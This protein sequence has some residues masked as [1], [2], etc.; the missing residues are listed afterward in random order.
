LTE[1]DPGHMSSPEHPLPARHAP[2]R[3]LDPSD[4]ADR[5]VF[6][7]ERWRASEIVTQAAIERRTRQRLGAFLGL[8]LATGVAAGAFCGGGCAAAGPKGEATSPPG[9]EEARAEIWR[10]Y[11]RTDTPPTITIVQGDDL[12]C[13]QR[14]GDPGFPAFEFTDAEKRLVG[15]FGGHTMSYTSVKVAWWPDLRPSRSSTAHEFMH[16]LLVRTGI[17]LFHHPTDDPQRWRPEFQ[18][19]GTVDQVN[20]QLEARGL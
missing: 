19:G 7:F 13:R 18:P 6:D 12:S 5:A 4:P 20:A 15:C 1:T 10:A 3:E 16:V 14:N 17:Y 9:Y 8:M 11:G 2:P